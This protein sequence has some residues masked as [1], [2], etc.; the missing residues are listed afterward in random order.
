M[1][2]FM[3]SKKCYSNIYKWAQTNAHHP[4]NYNKSILLIGHRQSLA[5]KFFRELVSAITKVSLQRWDK[6]SAFC[7]RQAKV[8]PKH[9][10]IHPRKLGWQWKNKHLKMYLLLKMVMF[11]C[12]VSF[13]RGISPYRP[14]LSFAASKCPCF[15]F[16]PHASPTSPFK[17]LPAL[18]IWPLW[19][20]ATTPAQRKVKTSMLHY[21]HVLI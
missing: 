11:H 6:K 16:R 14:H 4:T 15:P 10:P 7:R 12:H 8:T 1:I 2:W 3:I 17:H 18:G 19:H 21:H 5:W 13:R 9:T 20:M